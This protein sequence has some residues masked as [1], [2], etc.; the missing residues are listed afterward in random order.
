MMLS[1]PLLMLSRKS[2]VALVVLMGAASSVSAAGTA[3]VA[4]QGEQ[5][6]GRM[7][8]AWAGEHMRMD[9]PAQPG[10]HI[11]VRDGQSFA[12][13]HESGRSV[14][15]DMATMG[16]MAPLF[17]AR[18]GL[19]MNRAVSVDGI[20]PL[21]ESETV[22]GV[23]GARYRID[24][25]DAEGRP[26]S[27]TVVLT[28]DPRVVE[29]TQALRRHVESMQIA[30]ARPISV[31]L[32]ERGQGVLRFADRFEVVSIS[33]RVPPAEA[34]ALPAE[35]MSLFQVMQDLGGWFE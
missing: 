15:M 10:T 27:D 5:G 8:I 3:V 12:V 4:G 30:V 9:F 2:L 20:R 26:R 33:E 34:F 23:R 19:P 17:G 11:V 16:Q 29:L 14:V 18:L 6:S 22:A 24:W 25:T 21:G 31:A 35:P 28:D 13:T 32:R 7:E 1:G